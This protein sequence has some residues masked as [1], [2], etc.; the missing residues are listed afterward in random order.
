MGL[1]L[2]IL[3]FFIPKIHIN[4]NLLFKCRKSFAYHAVLHFIT[5]PCHMKISTQLF[6]AQFIYIYIIYTH[7]Y[8]LYV[9]SQYFSTHTYSSGGKSGNRAFLLLSSLGKADTTSLSDFLKCV[10]TWR[11]HTL[12]QKYI[13]V[14]RIKQGP[15]HINGVNSFSKKKK[16]RGNN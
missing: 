9:S 10:E 5:K 16:Q 3:L 1:Y 13:H 2:Q 8:T 4:E 15:C 14:V 7:T 12:L 6:N 11:L